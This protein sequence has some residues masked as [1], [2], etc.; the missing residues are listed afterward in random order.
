[1]VWSGATS[2]KK[3]VHGH[4]RKFLHRKN[5]SARVPIKMTNSKKT[6]A[7]PAPHPRYTDAQKLHWFACHP[8][9][10]LGSLAAGDARCLVLDSTTGATVLRPL[11]EC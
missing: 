6:P 8:D 2:A 5:Q 7:A 3:K 4:A 9:Y 10:R 1:V 11:E